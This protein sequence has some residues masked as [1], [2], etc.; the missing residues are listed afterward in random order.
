MTFERFVPAPLIVMTF[1]LTLAGCGSDSMSPVTPL[2]QTQSGG[3]HRAVCQPD[4]SLALSPASATITSGQSV[5][6]TAQLASICGLAGIVNVSIQNISPQP[7]GDNGFTLDQSRYDV[8]LTAY[9]SAEA[10][11]TFGAT[12]TTLKTTYII[13][14]Q[15]EDISGCCHGLQHSATFSLTVK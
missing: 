3:P 7:R 10:Y 11:V 2:D 9:G 5:R 4:F 8:P 15:G 6:V 14:I 12:A 13:T 1:L